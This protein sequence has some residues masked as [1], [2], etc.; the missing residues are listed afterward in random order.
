[1]QYGGEAYIW[2]GVGRVCDL[3]RFQVRK[4]AVPSP[5]PTF[6]IFK[7]EYSIASYTVQVLKSILLVKYERVVAA[8]FMDGEQGVIAQGQKLMNGPFGELRRYVIPQAGTLKS[9][10]SPGP[11][12]R[13]NSRNT[14]RR[15]SYPVATSRKVVEWDV[16]IWRNEF[17]K[18]LLED[19]KREAGDG[20]EVVA[21]RLQRENVCL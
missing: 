12:Y 15:A 13:S 6:P 3:K 10:L 1:M 14:L 7:Q 8:C 4:I 19:I 2:V 5:K 20:H 16:L 21:V 18:D 11:A 17:E 9:G